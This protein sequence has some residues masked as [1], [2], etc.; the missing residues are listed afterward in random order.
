MPTTTAPPPPGAS[1]ANSAAVTTAARYA[2]RRGKDIHDALIFLIDVS[3]PMLTTSTVV[4]GDAKLSARSDPAVSDGGGLSVPPGKG[5]VTLA[6][7]ALQGAADVLR[8]K[9]RSR[10][11]DVVGVIV[12]GTIRSRNQMNVPGVWVVRELAPPSVNAIRA[13]QGLADALAAGPVAPTSAGDGD[14]TDVAGVILPGHL[15]VVGGAAT[16]GRAGVADHGGSTCQFSHALWVARVMLLRAK[17]GPAFGTTGSGVVMGE[18]TA[19]R[20]RERFLAHKRV[21]VVTNCDDPAAGDAE[22]VKAAGKQAVDLADIG[23]FVR[24]VPLT[25]TP[26]SGAL[27]TEMAVAAPSSSL[28]ALLGG[29]TPSAGLSQRHMGRALSPESSLWGLP[30]APGGPTPSFDVHKFFAHIV[31]HTDAADADASEGVAAG[32]LDVIPSSNLETIRETLRREGM[33]KRAVARTVLRIGCGLHPRTLSALTQPLHA[34][35]SPATVPAGV[36]SQSQPHNPKDKE[37]TVGIAVYNRVSRTPVPPKVLVD[38]RTNLPVTAKSVTWCSETARPLPTADAV[39]HAY[40]LVDGADAAFSTAELNEIRCA[41]QRGGLCLVGVQTAGSLPRPEWSI[42]PSSFVVADELVWSGSGVALAALYDGCVRLNK[43]LIVAGSLRASGTGLRL[44]VLVPAE[45]K[46]DESGAVQIEPPGFHLTWLPYADDLYEGWKSSVPTPAVDPPS[47]ADKN[48]APVGTRR[49]RPVG[50]SDSTSRGE[51]GDDKEDDS[52]TPPPP[53]TTEVLDGDIV[54]V[55]TTVA[56]QVV[57]KMGLPPDF[58]PWK[59]KDPAL[60]RHWEVVQAIALAEALPAAGTP[61]GMTE[62]LAPGAA[63][64]PEHARGDDLSAAAAVAALP[65]DPL[66]PDDAAIEASA[67]DALATFRSTVLG[68]PSFDAVAAAARYGTATSRAA[69]LR[70]EK[71]AVKAAE[72]AVKREEAA[73]ALADVGP[74]DADAGPG[75]DGC[76]DR[77]TVAQLKVYCTAHGLPLVGRKAEVVARVRL[78]LVKA[79]EATAGGGNAPNDLFI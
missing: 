2:A 28:G 41:H 42:K 48:V 9:V 32:L 67:A 34:S 71:V 60:T 53:A 27:R 74:F 25:G 44:G 40:T 38:R 77:K 35:Q 37:L 76:L 50:N 6:S 78:H 51:D 79:V 72:A 22:Q 63:G 10:P 49:R 7:A 1:R 65:P 55:G 45:E 57:R 61:A 23:A 75:E 17:K 11:R 46:L 59:L 16:A 14:E 29:V 15:S 36:G 47:T 70:A 68:G 24:L 13:V 64:G 43:V 69:A 21:F 31:F 4:A 52:D 73:A 5:S 62:A 54:P 30:G 66:M 19:E 39:R 26:T 56:T 8:D 58:R 12:Y 33:P 20:T 3:L 18:A